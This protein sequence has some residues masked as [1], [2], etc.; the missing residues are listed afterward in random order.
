MKRLSMIW[1]IVFCVSVAA[2]CRHSTDVDG[3]AA[4][5]AAH[6][7][8]LG[9]VRLMGPVP[10]NE[11]LHM[12]ADPMCRTANGSPRA[13][14]DAVVVGTDGALANAFVELVGDFPETPVPTDTVAID[15]RAC[16]Y[17]PRVVA[18]RVGQSLQVRNSDAG[19]HNVHGV[20]TDRDSFNVSQPMSGMTNVFHP[21]DAG[22]LRLKC[23]V[24]TWMVAFV[25]VVNH[26]YFAVTGPDGSFT[27]H[28]VPVGTY[29]VRAWHERFGTLES[30]IHIESAHEATIEITFKN[31]AASTS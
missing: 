13:L 17:R 23:D 29:K 20:S 30:P 10:E 12:A 16:V 14:D 18:L 5:P 21:R 3:D 9:H 28:D 27:L 6:G 11:Q 4:L 25:G 8:V 15:Q 26:P 19:L 2:S 22:I 24:H 1:P 7:T 31:E